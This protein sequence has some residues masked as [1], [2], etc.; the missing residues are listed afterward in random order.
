MILSPSWQA[1]STPFAKR[2]LR[3]STSTFGKEL[4]SKTTPLTATPRPS[5]KLSAS[6]CYVISDH[7][8]IFFSCLCVSPFLRM[9]IY[10]FFSTD[11][12]AVPKMIPKNQSRKDRIIGRYMC[13]TY[14]PI[15]AA[16]TNVVCSTTYLHPF[17]SLLSFPHCYRQRWVKYP[18]PITHQWPHD[19]DSCHLS[20]PVLSTFNTYFASSIYA[21]FLNFLWWFVVDEK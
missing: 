15:T 21:Y 4:I 10:S 11:S 5:K 16:W 8:H 12:W 7:F 6:V 9:C 17:L 3:G 20:F 14:V 13:Y 18:S 1:T 2:W 19:I